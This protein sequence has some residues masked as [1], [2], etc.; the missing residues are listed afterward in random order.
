MHDHS[1]AAAQSYNAVSY[2][3][4]VRT[5]SVKNDE[6]VCIQNNLFQTCIY[7]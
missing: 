7:I 5:L 6:L 2:L 3:L 4:H 1:H